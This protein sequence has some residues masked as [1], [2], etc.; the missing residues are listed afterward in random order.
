MVYAIGYAVT[1]LCGWAGVL[2]I[3]A[4]LAYFTDKIGRQVISQYGGWKILYKWIED[5]KAAGR[6]LP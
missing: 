3:V 1:V 5:Q 4:A 2:L 6:K